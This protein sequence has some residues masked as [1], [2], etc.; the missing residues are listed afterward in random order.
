MAPAAN[1]PKSEDKKADQYVSIEVPA[2][3]E[4]DCST[5]PELWT[6]EALLAKRHQFSISGRLDLWNAQ[7]LQ[8][9]ILM[10]GS[11]VK[12]SS[13]RRWDKNEP[14][15][16]SPDEVD[17]VPPNCQ[18]LV[19]SFDTSYTKTNRADPSAMVLLGIFKYKDEE[20][21]EKFNAV[22][23]LHSAEVK[24]E[25]PEL[26][27]K[28]SDWQKEFNPDC[29]LIEDKGSGSILI[30][31]MRRSGVSVTA[32]RVKGVED[33]ITRLNSV[34]DMF[35][36]G[37]VFYIPT[38]QNARVIQQVNDVPAV[39]HDDLCDALVHGLRHIRRGGTIQLPMDRKSDTE[40]YFGPPEGFY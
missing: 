32:A 22:I 5:F 18:Y 13:W 33:K 14:V 35:T 37:L 16:G 38:P 23:L 28:I 6:T 1:G 25:Y 8:D 29:T 11:I 27:R 19:M 36:S 2:L 26:R 12:S 31:D 15:K 7:Y 34:A 9:P 30:Q 21:K 10:E 20:S 40:E 17:F 39:D 3:D 24:M 4:N